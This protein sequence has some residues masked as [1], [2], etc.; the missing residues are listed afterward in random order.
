M[1]VIPTP[2][3]EDP[4]VIA[5][6]QAIEA[7]NVREGRTSNG[8]GMSAIGDDCHRRTWLR[9]RWAAGE[10][11]TFKSLAAFQD[12]HDQEDVMAARLRLVQ[13]I[14]LIT[15]DP[16]TGKQI[17][18]EAWG[19][20]F[21][22]YQDGAILGLI[23]APKKWHV[24]EHKSTNE[25]KYADLQRQIE[26]LGEK[27]ALR[28]W[29]Q[30]Y[31]DQAQ[32]YMHYMGTDRHY[33][34]VSTPGGRDFLGLR[35]EYDAAH[36]LVLIARAERIIFSQTP[37][38][39]LPST[40]FMCKM[41]GIKDF[42][43]EGK[44]AARNCRTCLHVTPQPDGTWHCARWGKQVSKDEQQAGCPA[45]LYIPQLVP[46]RQLDASAHSVTYQLHDGTQWE[47]SEQGDKVHHVAVQIQHQE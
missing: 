14:T 15:L 25:R 12:G 16:E 2:P 47:N 41:C 1:P 32:L 5:V 46:G 31:Y 37:P 18:H 27:Y 7:K 8:V 6:K 3:A 22:G 38:E 39:K 42:C 30:Q 29:N 20:H 24:W 45:H 4:T 35:T 23:Q 34:T 40:H 21:S 44:W 43:H 13:G 28:Q 26:K 19:G 33:M 36:A 11:F 10:V 17:R 9:F